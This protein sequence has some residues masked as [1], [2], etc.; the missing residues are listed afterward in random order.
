[1]TRASLRLIPQAEDRCLFIASFQSEP[2]ALK[3]AYQILLAG[4]TPSVLEFLDCLTVKG[5]E[6]AMSDDFPFERGGKQAVL[7]VELDANTQIE[8]TYL[9]DLPTLQNKEIS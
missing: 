5:A 7:L 1:M 3:N 8:C 4:I 2:E 6:N 9:F